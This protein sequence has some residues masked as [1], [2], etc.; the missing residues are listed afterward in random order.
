[1]A[2]GPE[3]YA[4]RNARMH[5]KAQQEV[6][7]TLGLSLEEYQEQ[8]RLNKEREEAEALAFFERHGLTYEEVELIAKE[9]G[10]L[11]IEV[12]NDLTAELD[13]MNSVHSIASKLEAEGV[14]TTTATAKG[15]DKAEELRVHLRINESR[16]Q[17]ELRKAEVLERGY[18]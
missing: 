4:E 2:K 16:E 18:L 5:L 8:M 17:H 3:W 10:I 1:M 9:K 14:P 7:D 15:I 6:A 12:I 13:R 11:K